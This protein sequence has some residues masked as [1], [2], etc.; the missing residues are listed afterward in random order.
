MPAACRLFV[1]GEASCLFPHGLS[2]RP[3]PAMETRRFTENRSSSASSVR[4]Q[5]MSD[6]RRLNGTGAIEWPWQRVS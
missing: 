3:E 4:L 1:T 2:A 5:S 6:A